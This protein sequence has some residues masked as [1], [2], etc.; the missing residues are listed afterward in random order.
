MSDPMKFCPKGHAIYG[1]NAMQYRSYKGTDLVRCRHCYLE[2]FRLAKE[3]AKIR[4]E[5]R[6]TKSG[7]IGRKYVPDWKPLKR[8]PLEHQQRCEGIRR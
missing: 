4:N 8:N 5:G 7:Q 3:R 6:S 2:A 1:G